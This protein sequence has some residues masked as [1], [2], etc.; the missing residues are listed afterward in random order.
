MALRAFRCAA[1]GGTDR[2]DF[3]PPQA[4]GPRLGFVVAEKRPGITGDPTTLFGLALQKT[5]HLAA[6]RLDAICSRFSWRSPS[7]RH[8]G[9]F[10][11]AMVSFERLKSPE[12]HPVE[13]FLLQLPHSGDTPLSI[14]FTIF[15]PSCLACKQFTDR[16]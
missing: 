16:P 13:R 10:V 1:R 3:K 2:V 4:I 15:S 11:K 14:S 8:R 7:I 12:M 6:W 5:R 9:V